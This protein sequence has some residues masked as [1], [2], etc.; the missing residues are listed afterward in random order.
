MKI[1]ALFSIKQLKML[2]V[3]ISCFLL[4]YLTASA[5]SNNSDLYFIQQE[6]IIVTG[7]VTDI[8][9]GVP[10]PGVN[11]SIEGTVIGTAT[12]MNGNYSIETSS[13]AIL[14][15]SFIGYQNKSIKVN[16]RKEI[17]VSMEIAVTEIEEVVAVGYGTE[18]RKN[19]TS[20]IAS[21]NMNNV[22]KRTVVNVASA[23]QGNITG[24]NIIEANATPGTQMN[25]NIRGINSP[26]GN[27]PPLVIV[28]GIETSGFQS[29]GGNKYWARNQE[30]TGIENI[31]PQDIEN[32][33]VLKDASAAAIYGSRAANGVI[34]ITT[35]SGKKG[36]TE[37]TYNGHVGMSLP[38]KGPEVCNA[39]QYVSILQD[40]YGE[41]LSMGVNI[42]QA[43]KDYVANPN[44]FQT[45]DWYD[46]LYDPAP[47]TNHNFAVSSGGDI[48]NF[49]LSANYSKENG[50]DI[51]SSNEQINFMI[52]SNFNVSKKLQ[53]SQTLSL[54]QAKS[55]PEIYAFGRPT[56]YKALNMYPYFS[57]FYT[58]D[59]PN[60]DQ[61]FEVGKPHYGSFYYG[62]GANPED[63]V[64]N[65]FTLQDFWHKVNRTK[66]VMG[67]I[68]AT[69]EI[70]EGLKYE[71]G[72]YYNHSFGY[73]TLHFTTTVPTEYY[74]TEN[75]IDKRDNE[76]SNWKVNS[77]LRYDNNFGNHNIE[78]LAGF[79]AQEFRTSYIR[80]R[81]GGF[82]S[83]STTDINSPGADPNVTR[84][85]G[86]EDIYRVNSILSKLNY[87]YNDRYLLTINFRRDG[88]SKFNSDIRWGNFP[89][90]SAGWRMSN[91]SF[92]DNL[93]LS[94][95]INEFKVRGGY[96]ELGRQ[97]KGYYAPSPTLRYTPYAFGGMV[98][99]GLI[100]SSPVNTQITWETSQVT[101]IGIDFSLL[102]NQF[103]GSAE[104][105]HRRTNNLMSSIRIPASA[106]GGGF[107]VNDGEI[108]NKGMEFS[109]TYHNYGEKLRFNIGLNGSY[110]TTELTS[111]PEDYQE[112][113]L[114]TWDVM[115]LIEMYEGRSP[116]EF[117]LVESDGIFKSQAEVDNY[118]N[119]EGDLIQPYAEVGDVK[120]IDADG[121][122][123]ISF[124][125]DRTYQGN[126]IPPWHMGLNLNMDYKNFDLTMNFY[127]NFGHRVYNGPAFFTHTPYGFSN[128]ST[129]L[130]NAYDPVSNPNSNIPRNNPDDLDGNKNSA[131]ATTT[132][133][134]KG[135]FVKAKLIQL[136][137]TLP[138]SLT[139][140]IG[141]S[142]VRVSL[143]INNLFT[144]TSYSG[145]DPEQMGMG[146]FNWSENII[147]GAGIDN[148][149]APQV[150]QFLF[151]INVNF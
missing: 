9:T 52:K 120:Y 113:G 35:K 64:R 105:F 118:V 20:S 109:I 39:E 3:L 148:G 16:G 137:Y 142:S 114:P 60:K 56:Y 70:L 143:S 69:Y 94:D 22:S 88:S 33:E 67:N 125:K 79:E 32:I 129:D 146:G 72:G 123:E 49:R 45:Y 81:K 53:I 74:E 57:P 36:K 63:F 93:G 37:V 17:N 147:N 92:W 23:L 25:I 136:G 135:N 55:K 68:R 130:L 6:K 141:I 115:H 84:L 100:T 8:Q 31:N 86:S 127:G 89:G 54:L 107:D 14:I 106:G 117:W 87:N 83:S 101:N 51:N 150:K 85:N 133:L 103:T 82:L 78:V 102:R 99:D 132:W 47:V 28:D 66:N 104:Y 149:A 75:T 76:S 12:D 43:A 34:L 26:D 59:E 151:G 1:K 27:A 139:D 30:S 112:L 138:K 7:I 21:A 134:E 98:V 65:P 48:G 144:L 108:N 124:D 10:L 42:P 95:L 50:I 62:G 24:L 140:N 110:H 131:A 41:D 2:V 40:M 61:Y 19:V 145:V 111:I 18:K 128:F 13:N 38:F 71:A 126:G 121:D 4:N 73:S 77:F 58:E 29:K 97:N 116:G 119:S 46:E 15:F 122:G 80:Y 96:G 11:V 44:K 90:I 91:E 5:Y